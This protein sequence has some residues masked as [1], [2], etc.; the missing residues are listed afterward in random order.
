VKKQ[1]SLALVAC[2]VLVM[3]ISLLLSACTPASPTATAP[4]PTT[5]KPTTP[6]ATTPA[7]TS[8]VA[9]TTP[10]ATKPA[11]APSATVYNWVYQG[12]Q[13]SGNVWDL[14]YKKWASMVN[15]ASGGRIKITCRGS[16]E[17]VPSYQILEAVKNGV[18][19]LGGNSQAQMQALFGD[20]GALMGSGLPAGPM[21][22]EQTAW[23]YIGGGDALMNELIKD[24]AVNVVWFSPTPEAFGF[25]IKPITS[26]E[27]FKGM[28]FRT[29]GLWGKILANWGASV[30]TVT[31]SEIY[32]AAKTGI[33]DAFEFCPPGVNWPMGFHEVMPYMGLP[34]IHSPGAAGGFA[35]SHKNWDTL[36]ADLK[37]ILFETG[38]SFALLSYMDMVQLDAEAMVKYKAYGTKIFYVPDAMQQEIA[39][40][41]KALMAE[42]AAKDATFKKFYDHMANFSKSYRAACEGAM[43]KYCIFD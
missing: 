10:T 22:P 7:V 27:D 40:A 2:T 16:G 41:S 4:A 15:E 5:P 19:D 29:I 8:T 11:P 23:Y 9:P 21:S 38:R 13:P 32:Q 14:E 36:P 20:V 43:T 17:I 28:K 35:I 1:L 6:A 37:S 31:G 25:F 26:K 30:I 42:F 12:E 3:I 39:D 18:L 33:V 34:G 24:Y